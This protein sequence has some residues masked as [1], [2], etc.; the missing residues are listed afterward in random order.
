MVLD[1]TTQRPP[2][3]RDLLGMTRPGAYAIASAFCLSFAAVALTHLQG[4]TNPG[5]IVLAVVLVAYGVI[6]ILAVP[7]DPISTEW[8]L[9]LMAIG[10]GSCALVLPQLP[11]D[12]WTMDQAWNLRATTAILAF[13]S[14]RGRA[15]L[16]GFG[17]VASL[18]ACACWSTLT[19]QGVWTGVELYS[20]NF[21]TI[22]MSIVFAYSVRPVV[23]LV[24]SLRHREAARA[25]NEARS[26]GA[27]DERNALLAEVDRVVSPLL[28]AA[29]RG[30]ELDSEARL[31]C[32]LA[33][34]HLRDLL[35]A[36]MLAKSSEVSQ[37]V[38]DARRRGCSVI[39]LDD[40]VDRQS[41]PRELAPL[42]DVIRTASATLGDGGSMTV[43]IN[44][45]GRDDRASVVTTTGDGNT[46]R[47]TI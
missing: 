15:G 17:A 22:L 1:A 14:V 10:P 37:A 4:I 18:F 9:G 25:A 3:V 38:A 46:S 5:S 34:A 44:P 36:P 13:L 26:R 27:L 8:S 45:E 24:Y 30:D 11:V 7:G 41:W 32:R 20:I 29:G 35:R 43:R 28:E 6:A 12:T 16:A 19:G 23:Q 39:L 2:D 21:A 40:R 47:F 33:E 42:W 31:S